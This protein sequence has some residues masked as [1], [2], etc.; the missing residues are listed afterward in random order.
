MQP[1]PA[2]DRKCTDL[3]SL[4]VFVGVIAAW[5]GESITWTMA[6]SPYLLYWPRDFR[7]AYC[8]LDAGYNGGLNLEA[9]G[10]RAY[11]M[12]MTEV[13]DGAARLLVCSPPAARELRALLGA[14]ALREH[15]RLCS[16]AAGPADAAGLDAEVGRRIGELTNVSAAGVWDHAELHFVP[17]CAERCDLTVRAVER[18]SFA[19]RMPSDAPLARAFS[20]LAASPS[21]DPQIRSI[22]GS[23]F[24]FSALPRSACPYTARHCV[25]FPDVQ[26][27]DLGR[28]ECDMT[29]SREAAGRVGSSVVSELELAA[30][31][32]F[33]RSRAALGPGMLDAFFA[34]TAAFGV[35]CAG[36]VVLGI[37]VLVLLRFFTRIVVWAALGLV[38][39]FLL[40]GGGVLHASSGNCMVGDGCPIRYEVQNERVRWILEVSAYVTWGL[41]AVWLIVIYRVR[42]VIRLAIALT[43]VSAIFMCHTPAVLVVPLLQAVAGV[44][45]CAWWA[46]STAALLSQVPEDHTPPG[47]YAGP[48]SCPSDWFGGF[49]WR[50]EGDAAL[51]SHPCSG[52]SGDTSGIV[53]RCW[54]CASPRLVV[55]SSAVFGCCGLLWCAAFLV[56]MA[57]SIVAGACVR[58]F[59]SN[60]RTS[61]L[62]VLAASHFV[63]RYHL[64]S[65]AFG[66][67]L[68]T[69]TL[70]FRYLFAL[71]NRMAQI[72]NKFAR[73]LLHLPIMLSSPAVW[74]YQKFLRLLSRNAFIQMAL[75]G[76]VFCISAKDSVLLV[77]R[78]FLRFGALSAI[79]T[80][81]S[82]VLFALHVV[83]TAIFGYFA[84]GLLHPEVNI[85]VPMIMNLALGI[86]VGK[87]YSSVVSITVDTSLQCMMLSS[88]LGLDV[89]TGVVPAELRSFMPGLAGAKMTPCS[90]GDEESA[91]A[92]VRLT[93]NA[94]VRSAQQLLD[95]TFQDRSVPGQ[96]KPIRLKAIAVE[97]MRNQKTMQAYYERR[98]EL[99]RK[100]LDCKPFPVLTESVCPELSSHNPLDKSINEYLFFH[101]TS[102]EAAKSILRD[103]FRLPKTHTHGGIYGSGV[104]VAESNSKAHSYCTRDAMKGWPMLIVRASLGKVH[105]TAEKFPDKAGLKRG[106]ETGSYDS[107]CGDRKQIQQAFG[108]W[109]EFI[110]YDVNQ[111]LAEYLVW[112]KEQ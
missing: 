25:P 10:R 62:R 89:D 27:S 46:F 42:H 71:L 54:R 68:I 31:A 30:E 110:V 98:K 2:T 106:V 96:H 79:R 83:V 90:V 66:S 6:G 61:T 102:E 33:R 1:V 44:L 45:L 7:G 100:R 13:L 36:S 88:E 23:R 112:V 84:L 28:R 24:V 55:R 76:K 56:A 97:S 81:V 52:Y 63:V 107:I 104:Y 43:K 47:H 111:V 105:S 86:L 103:D 70:P 78:H 18:R 80:L 67:L 37:V 11:T 101:G 64:G 99:G 19:Y 69:V 49:A 34:S 75:F 12:N 87:L 95:K 39:G 93:G 17:V 20:L 50:D 92:S 41:A 82:Y 38:L 73:L 109:R 53:P 91:R 16:G 8:G 40:M 32:T 15:G 85:I 29:M 5:A 74:V 26:L 48:S 51:E 14:D 35:T 57:Q 108:G 58:W 22:I 4:I 77:L 65:L 3:L 72:Q 21:V 60:G 9:H 94:L 59:F